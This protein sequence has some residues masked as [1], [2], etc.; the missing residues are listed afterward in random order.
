MSNNYESEISVLKLFNEKANKLEGLHFT[1]N[2]IGYK[3]GI[4]YS[5]DK[6]QITKIERTGPDNEDIDAFVLTFRLFIQDNEKISLH[7][8][9][10]IYQKLPIGGNLVQQFKNEYTKI[11]QF[12]DNPVNEFI[13]LPTTTNRYLME[14]FIYGGLAHTNNKKKAIYDSWCS[15]QLFPLFEEAFVNIVTDVLSTII[16]IRKLNEEVLGYLEVNV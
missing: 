12:L 1:K 15:D 6:G 9:A 3:S 7:N 4:K 13:R 8:M 5:V 2:M 11:N 14:V 16:K 10:N